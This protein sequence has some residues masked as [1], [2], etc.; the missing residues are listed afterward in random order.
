MAAW[1]DD[2]HVVANRAFYR[3]K[4]ATLVPRLAPVLDAPAPDAGFYLWARVPGGDDEAF[5]RALFGATHVTVLPGRYLGREAHGVN[6]GRGYVRIALVP[7][8]DEC[9]EAADRIAATDGKAGGIRSV[10]PNGPMLLPAKFVGEPLLIEHFKVRDSTGQVVGIAARHWANSD[11]GM[12]STWSLLL[13]A[14]GSLLLRAPGET[15]TALDAA[16]RRAGYSPGSVWEG[17]L[18]VPFATGGTV[19]GGTGDF[20]SLTGSYTETWKVTGVDASGAL[21]GTIELYTSTQAP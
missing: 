6:P 5:A 16:L 21:R 1:Q 14:R 20:G 11:R 15:S 13:P 8:L 7:E 10:V 4:F 9:V 2:A 3:E 18:E 19:A 12:T 17:T